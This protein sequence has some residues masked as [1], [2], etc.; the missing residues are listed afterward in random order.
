MSFVRNALSVMFTS[1]VIVPLGLVTSIVLARWLSVPDRSLLAVAL[2]FTAI[3]VEA[4]S[5][6]LPSAS[7]YRLRRAQSHPSRVVSAE[8]LLALTFSALAVAVCWSIKPMIMDGFL[9][10]AA[11]LVFLLAV[12][13][14]PFQQLSAVLNGI[15]RGIDRFDLQ[16]AYRFLIQIGT[17][18]GLLAA[19]VFWK[20][21]LLEALVAFL[22]VR[23][24][25]SLL[26]AAAVIRTTGMA[27]T[28]ERNEIT[29]SLSFGFKSYAQNLAGQLHERVDVFMLAYLLDDPSQVAFYAIAIG[30]AEQLKLIPEGIGT[31]L[32]PQLAGMSERSAGSLTAAVSRH[33]LIWTVA[34][35]LLLVPAAPFLIPL[36]YGAP[37]EASVLPFLVLLPAVALLTVFRVPTRYFAASAKQGIT[38]SVF[39]TSAA[40]NVALNLL[41]IPLYGVL[42]AAMATLASYVLESILITIL[43]LKTS[44][45][46]VSDMLIFRRDDLEPYRR[47]LTAMARRTGLGR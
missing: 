12:A 31:A 1:A 26:L 24:T 22:I 16:N 40:V 36:L 4:S 25:F 46:K 28:I 33:S 15:A 45:Q 37:Y 18:S 43:F 14:V 34:C 10:G 13:M 8:M 30:V 29:Q 17:L 9:R 3:T 44:G 47:R 35:V 20:G 39:A 5:L 2:A 38:V 27:P 7:V 41:L 11:P 21:G 23:I 32:F 42:G 6:G 19:L